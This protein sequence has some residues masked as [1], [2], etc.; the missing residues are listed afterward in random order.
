MKVLARKYQRLFIIMLKLLFRRFLSSR[1]LLRI[2]HDIVLRLLTHTRQSRGQVDMTLVALTS[3]Y[4]Y[5]LMHIIENGKELK[6]YSKFVKELSKE[7]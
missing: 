7:K 2:L 5:L 6:I 1:A 4:L 3:D